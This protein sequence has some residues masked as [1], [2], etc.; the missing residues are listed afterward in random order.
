MSAPRPTRRTVSEGDVHAAERYLEA[1]IAEDSL[2]TEEIRTL[3]AKIEA[4]RKGEMTLAE[5]EEKYV[6]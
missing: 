1:L 2:S 5:F 4:I 6:G 3:R